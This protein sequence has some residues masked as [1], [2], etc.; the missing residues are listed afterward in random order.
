MALNQSRGWLLAYDIANPRR[1]NRVHRLIVKHC[2][3]VQ[4]SLYYFEGSPR[5][6]Q[7]LLA[8]LEALINATA[9]DVRAYPLPTPADIVTLG[10][11][12][13]PTAIRILSATQPTLPD[14]LQPR[15]G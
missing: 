5:A 7:E 11:S 14:M 4:Y 1:L 10:R 3:P 9:D 8:D 6:L 2:V 12:S 15:K 13:L